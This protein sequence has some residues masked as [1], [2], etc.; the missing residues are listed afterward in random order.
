MLLQF[1]CFPLLFFQVLESDD[2]HTESESEDDRAKR[3]RSK[4]SN[5]RRKHQ[6]MWTPGEVSNLIDGI[7][8]YGTG[9]WT[10]IKNLFFSSSAYRTPIDLRVI[11]S[12]YP[13]ELY[14]FS[15][16]EICF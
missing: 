15:A 3:R 13:I 10:D 16:I 8:Q 12:L 1:S 7:A 4:K 5:D 14:T 11:S 9:R 2:D 6:R